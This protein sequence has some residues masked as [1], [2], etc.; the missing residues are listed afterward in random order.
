MYSVMNVPL[1]MGEVRRGENIEFSLG[2]HKPLP[3]PLLEGEGLYKS[4]LSA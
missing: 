1:P 4:K 2:H 3:N